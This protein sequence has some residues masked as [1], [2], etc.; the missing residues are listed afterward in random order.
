MIQILRD[1]TPRKQLALPII[2]VDHEICPCSRLS[3]SVF[4]VRTPAR[5]HLLFSTSS[6]TWT[7]CLKATCLLSPSKKFSKLQKKKLV[8]EEKFGW[9]FASKATSCLFVCFWFKQVPDQGPEQRVKFDC[10]LS[11]GV[12]IS[13]LWSHM[14]EVWRPVATVWRFWSMVVQREMNLVVME[15]MATITGDDVGFFR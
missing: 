11:A 10:T 7:F 15:W 14:W 5:D 1:R 9:L 3:L 13:G 6:R 12:M 8:L 4:P 2:N